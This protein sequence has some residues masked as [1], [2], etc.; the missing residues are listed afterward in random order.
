MINQFLDE[1]KSIGVFGNAEIAMKQD[2]ISVLLSPRPASKGTFVPSKNL[3]VKEDSLQ[4]EILFSQVG[5]LDDPQDYI[6][7]VQM[8]TQE[9]E[10]FYE[11]GA[12][13]SH[14]ASLTFR[15]V[16]VTVVEGL[17]LSGVMNINGE[18][19]YPLMLGNT[20]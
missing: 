6:V 4:I 5:Y 14:Y 18:L 10:W 2:W 9:S 3:C 1:W 11:E 7:G 17:K 13:Y 20:L 8:S 19:F 15:E 12:S 16:E